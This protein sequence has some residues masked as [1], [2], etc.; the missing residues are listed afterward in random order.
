[1]KQ[2]L[3]LF[4][5]TLTEKTIALEL[6]SLKNI[7]ADERT[8]FIVRENLDKYTTNLD[9][10]IE[11]LK[12]IETGDNSKNDSG[13]DSEENLTVEISEKI[14]NFEKRS[15]MNYE[16]ATF[17]I[18]KELGAVKDSISVFVK[19]LNNIILE[20]Q[21]FMDSSE[22][23]FSIEHELN[24]IKEIENLREKI[25]DSILNNIKELSSLEEEKKNSREKIEN[26]RDSK[27]YSEEIENNREIENKHKEFEKNLYELKQMI[28]FKGLANLFHNN[29]KKMSII[30]E[31]NL[32]FTNSFLKD[33]GASLI[34]LLEEAE[35]TNYSI[36]QKINNIIEKRKENEAKSGCISNILSEKI[37]SLEESIKKINQETKGIE[38]ENLKEKAK[39]GKLEQNKRGLI[40]S[41]K[42]SSLKMNVE[43]K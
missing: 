29:P 19:D 11:N 15:F 9:K 5:K 38:T 26:I 18:G 35:K 13:D 7:R 32:N 28:D 8:K 25:N 3:S 14:N 1:M 40:S 36:I 41:I 24:E 27:E 33:N 21:D 6:I 17:L 23:L 30:S 31:H 16:K 37:S 34:K 39:S 10:L 22:N 42:K 4:I 20:N 2:R 12:N 43:I